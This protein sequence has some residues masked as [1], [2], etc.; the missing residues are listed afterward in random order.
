MYQI[1]FTNKMKRDVKRM[2][3]RGKDISK[4][5]SVLSVLA[6]GNRLPDRNR[7][8]PLIGNRSGFREC[9]IESD[10]VLV[11]RI[12]NDVLILTAIETGTHADIFG[13]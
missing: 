3:N 13:L 2:K 11:Y 6:S 12:Q 7:D 1:F 4:L 8:H 9:H 10:W 5:I